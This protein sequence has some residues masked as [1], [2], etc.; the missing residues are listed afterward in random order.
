M[1]PFGGDTVSAFSIRPATTA[2]LPAIVAIYNSTVASRQA[3][4]D[5]Q[6]VT[7]DERQAW[8]AAHGGN[9][10]LF[11]VCDAN[12]AVC[13]WSSFSDFYPR[14]AYHI[15]AEISIYVAPEQRGTGLGGQLLDFM[16]GKASALGI[17]KVLA[18][19]FAHN[20]P[21]LALF[22]ARG[23]ADWGLLPQICDLQ[24]FTADIVILGKSL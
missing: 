4:A 20:T 2:D 8:F 9:R 6:P 11:V 24:S 22:R 13:A 16:L 21:S 23:F 15:S 10:P 5:L 12:G 19:V 18:F 14:P 3:T 17:R 7:V 1:P